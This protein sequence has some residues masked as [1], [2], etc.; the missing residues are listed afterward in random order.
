MAIQFQCPCGRALIADEAHQGLSVKCPACGRDLLV[1]GTPAAP[2]T[3]LPS[4]TATGAP[5]PHCGTSP[6]PGAKHCQ[7]C[8][9]FLESAS[10]P[11]PAFRI[12]GF[13]GAQILASAAVCRSCG[14]ASDSAPSQADPRP[15]L[16]WEHR[17]SLGLWTAAFQ[18]IKSVLLEPAEAFR[19][20]R[21]GAAG[22][23]FLFLV[24][25]GCGGAVVGAVWQAALQSTLMGFL[26]KLGPPQASSGPFNPAMMG[27][28]QGL[29]GIVF[30]P[31]VTILS[32]LLAASLT[33]LGL[34]VTGAARKDF[35]TTLAVYA[36]VQ[37]AV[38]LFQLVPVCGGIVG[39]VWGLVCMI[40]GIVH[41]HGCQTWKGVLAVLWPILLGCCCGIGA[42]VMIPALMSA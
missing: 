37:G 30:A 5:C 9:A 35:P 2:A 20:M 11:A 10:G 1:P 26:S 14:R 33:H 21:T 22:D 15:G 19:I 17:A 13:C 38:G 25:F 4:G 12:C 7:K 8:G 40:I 28:F 23:A 6:L 18:T 27:L 41:A 29:L 3:V 16:P 39:A 34:L 24:I 31:F 36:Y 32:W 42:A